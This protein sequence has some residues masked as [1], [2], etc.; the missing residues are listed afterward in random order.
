MKD[1]A[2]IFFKPQTDK[3]RK[4]ACKVQV[5]TVCFWWRRNEPKQSDKNTCAIE[6]MT[7]REKERGAI[8]LSTGIYISH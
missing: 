4:E 2:R 6:I 5:A 8:D 7:T 3:S 1:P